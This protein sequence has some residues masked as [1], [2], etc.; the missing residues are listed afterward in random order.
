VPTLAAV[1]L[2]ASA[3]IVLVLGGL[4]LL[5][6][7]RGPKFF[8]RDRALLD[9]MREVPLVI[10]RQTTIW[11]AGIG[12]HAS[13]SFGAVLFGALYLYL[14]L[15]PAHFLAR[16]PFLL[17]LGGAY[18]LGMAILARVYWFN[19]PFAGILAALVLYAAA[20]FALVA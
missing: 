15:E 13:H 9:K 4:H 7:F 11:R 5:Y 16:S 10:S 8:P 1:L 18:L 19:I 2:S 3:L 17:A 14:A 6:T 20:V 12:F